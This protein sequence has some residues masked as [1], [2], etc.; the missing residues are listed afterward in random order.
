MTGLTNLIT[1]SFS[2]FSWL[3]SVDLG[4]KEIEEDGK[5]VEGWTLVVV[6]PR[7]VFD[8]WQY[9]YMVTTNVLINALQETHCRQKQLKS[10]NFI[11]NTYCKIYFSF[12]GGNILHSHLILTLPPA[13]PG[14]QCREL[15]LSPISNPVSGV[16]MDQVFLQDLPGPA[17][18]VSA[19]A[20][21]WP[22]APSEA[23]SWAT[24]WPITSQSVD[25]KIKTVLMTAEY[26]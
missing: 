12:I 2:D 7:W 24:N 10:N 19:A 23:S 17:Q 22:S 6:K 20:S 26:N 11:R 5:R 16:V 21:W 13:L 9:L 1:Q 18:H 14:C 4:D 15:S 3:P 25:W 8:G